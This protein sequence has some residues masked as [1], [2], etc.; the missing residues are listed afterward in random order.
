MTNTNLSRLG[1]L[2]A[3]ATL[4]LTLAFSAAAP[5]LAQEISPEALAL[6]R[7]YVDLTDKAGLYEA[8]LATTASQTSKLL[9]SQSPDITDKIDAAIVKV[10]DQYKGKKDDMFNQ[11][12][13]VYA[14]NFTQDELK[15]I[16][17][18]Y[19][20]PVGQKLASSNQTVSASIHDVMRVW[21]YNFGTEF[22]SKV[23]AE[24]KAEG[25]KL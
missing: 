22:V 2:A 18:F 21:V 23:R 9:S 20:S 15:Q 10:L 24:L 14:M 16:V 1:K 4:A 25:Y 6:A 8:T 3:A 12:A 19:S 7:K 5:V 11:F 13:R 17:D